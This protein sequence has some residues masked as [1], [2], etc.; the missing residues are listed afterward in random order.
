[1]E[2]MEIKS[3][4]EMQKWQERFC[5]KNRVFFRCYDATGKAIT[6][7]SGERAGIRCIYSLIGKFELRRKMKQMAEHALNSQVPVCMESGTKGLYYLSFQNRGENMSIGV[8][9]GL[10]YLSEGSKTEHKKQM[11]KDS[12][13]ERYKRTANEKEWIIGQLQNLSISLEDN[14]FE[15]NQTKDRIREIKKTE[16]Q[17]IN[18]LKR[19]EVINHIMECL[20][21]E[22]DIAKIV[23]KAFVAMK[24]YVQF[25]HV[26]LC[27]VNRS[28]DELE[29][30]GEWMDTSVNRKIGLTTDAIKDIIKYQDRKSLIVADRSGAEEP[31]RSILSKYGIETVISVSIMEGREPDIYALFA[32][33]RFARKCE[34]ENMNFVVEVCRMIQN[35]LY[36]RISKNSLIS[37]YTAL[38]EILNNLGSGIY[39]IDKESKE[40]LFANDTVNN[41]AGCDVV[42]M[43][44]YQFRYQGRN[45]G[46]ATCAP[47]TR[48]YYYHE[49]YDKYKERWYEVTYN[50]ITWVDGRIVSLCNLMD[51]TD[52]KNYQKRI[53]YQANNDFLTGLFNRKRCEEDLQRYIMQAIES[54]K[55]GTV[56][57]IDLDDFKHINDGLGHQYGDQ[58]LK[59]IAD[60]LLEIPGV[61]DHCYRIGG[62][63]FLIVIEP[64]HYGELNRMIA[65][66]QK[67]FLK[68]WYL[69]HTEFY[70]TMSM[71][72]VNYGDPEDNVHD[73]IKKADIAM[74]DAKKGG[75]NRYV[76]YNK[77]EDRFSYMKFDMETNMRSA[78][79]AKCSEFEVY[80]Q[81]IV[82]VTTEDCIGGE[83][84]VRWNSKKLGFLT[85][86]DF[87]PLA[88][89]LG[90]ITPIGEY[91]LKEA[92][93]Y[94]KKW[95]DMGIDVRINVNLSIIQLLA[96]NIVDVIE[97]VITDT[98]VNASNLVL[99]VT[100]S[101]AIND[102][103][104]MKAV[105]RNIKK[106][107]VRI[108]LD[109]FGT[110]YSSLNYI[111][112]MDLDIIKVDRTF[113]KDIA[114]DAYAKA[115]VKLIA[116]LSRELDVL[117]CVE[118]VEEEAQLRVLKDMNISMIQG[119]YFGKPM[120]MHMFE[121][122]YLGIA[123][124]E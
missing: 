108:A 104:R 111:K 98:G 97:K 77:G 12:L 28:T 40:I 51:V 46:C 91:V 123:T 121:K 122:D 8:W 31:L 5:I 61:A 24:E 22:D 19:K 83:A 44:C 58:L 36:R 32:E 21:E 50:D 30:M 37:S 62:D 18:E 107:G 7:L 80:I 10:I 15:T 94:N 102:M 25:S 70:C 88:E 63:E 16:L 89:H 87:V 48:R 86:G 76:H 65:D 3:I 27:K 79:A 119:Y 47:L 116:D 13:L 120:K 95:S 100:E 23:N 11:N 115:F 9:S 101:L 52:K 53:E 106:L 99:E 69:E 6:S 20:D 56:L 110:G 60:G 93:T 73:L 105:I 55:K 71:G 14:G 57:F 64:E 29:C 117:V 112:Q 54:G 43:P 59:L 42:G 17:I 75:K 41:M 34:P 39:V 84:L 66:V 38:K 74:Y 78:I 67:L 72:I 85:P 96:K 114:E 33:E 2:K 68:P 103:N 1:M 4:D 113:I 26:I 82:D 118:G 92:C 81:P 90:L 49:V 109:D 45:E 124:N 35:M